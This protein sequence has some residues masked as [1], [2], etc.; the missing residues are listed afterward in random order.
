MKSRKRNRMKGYDYSMPWW[1]FVT[2]CVNSKNYKLST[3]EK[4][5]TNLTKYGK[6]V[7][8]VLLKLP[9]YYERFELDDYVIMPDHF[10]GIFILN[11]RR[12]RSKTDPNKNIKFDNF[13][14]SPND[15]T[16]QK[17]NIPEQEQS[18]TVPYD[19]HGLSE[20]IKSLKSFSSR[21]I[22][23]LITPDRFKWQKSFYDR[24]IRNEKELY[25]IRRYIQQNPLKYDLVNLDL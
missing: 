13:D 4:G 20:I 8:N 22:N 10:H 5:K 15:E 23:K 14:Q 7:E 16:N 11:E 21:E 1:Y 3:I 17:F 2:V 6:I 24:I 18:E 9:N 25:N 12:D 19:R